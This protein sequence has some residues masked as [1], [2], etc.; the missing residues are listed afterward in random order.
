MIETVSVMHS[1]P[2]KPARRRRSRNASSSSA[3]SY[4][5]PRTPMDAYSGLDAGRLGRGFS[6][7][8]MKSRCASSEDADVFRSMTGAEEIEP[9]SV[10]DSGSKTPVPLPTWLCETVST[11]GV[12]HPLRV[13][14]PRPSV[15][16]AAHEYISDKS[17]HAE[18]QDSEESIFA[19]SVANLEDPRYTGIPNQ[20]MLPEQH[21]VPQLQQHI[22]TQHASSS[23]PRNNLLHIADP[24]S[25]NDDSSLS[26]LG[27]PLLKDYPVSFSNDRVPYSSAGP[28]P[29]NQ[30][31]TGAGPEVRLALSRSPV[32]LFQ[33]VNIDS[34]VE[35]AEAHDSTPFSRPGPLAQ[36]HDCSFDNTLR[37]MH[38]QTGLE[39]QPLPPYP[40]ILECTQFPSAPLASFSPHLVS[41]NVAV[42][43][44]ERLD[45]FQS[46]PQD[47]PQEELTKQ[48]GF[49]SSLE[50]SLTP[51]VPPD[52][53]SEET[54]QVK[55]FSTPGPVHMRNSPFKFYFDDPAEDPCMSDPLQEADY[56]LA[57]DYGVDI[58]QDWE[59][60]DV[61][62]DDET[63]VGVLDAE[64]DNVCDDPEPTL[65]S[66]THD[67]TPTTY[68]ANVAAER[69]LK[70]SKRRSRAAV[71]SNQSPR[72]LLDSH[73]SDDSFRWILSDGSDPV[74]NYDMNITNKAHDGDDAVRNGSAGAPLAPS[75]APAP[76]IYISPLREREVKPETI[77]NINSAGGTDDIQKPDG[78]VHVNAV[79][80][81]YL[82][83]RLSLFWT[84]LIHDPQNIKSQDNQASMH[85]S[86]MPEGTVGEIASEK[87]RIKPPETP[88]VRV[89][90]TDSQ[91][92]KKTSSMTSHHPP[93]GSSQESN[94]SI[95]SWTL[96][97]Q[98]ENPLDPADEIERL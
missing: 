57:L 3:T 73:P 24:I 71:Y 31:D 65:L 97:D 33:N 51:P 10:S 69:D 63:A 70:T 64:A 88:S 6:V 9:I 15:P 39:F 83:V 8:K 86:V 79:N 85:A 1:P 42:A 19:F 45:I 34:L 76:G 40:K 48:Y 92:T 90:G 11:L 21:T 30:L 25:Y 32:D 98:V 77:K 75:F 4:D 72:H 82:Q 43:H 66:F 62:V 46:D 53:F 61:D 13:I 84:V 20:P 67:D 96:E 74:Q 22:I 55:P 17:S 56:A 12:K 60:E 58:V 7:I 18:L 37:P 93:C 81:V 59:R 95:E 29:F 68:S 52:V 41:S 26:V 54:D 38:Q 36:S 80:M 5:M 78:P 28:A 44:V 27:G 49:V 35:D 87:M 14:L 50:Y 2:R 23:P 89:D 47:N 94:D 16:D 91:G